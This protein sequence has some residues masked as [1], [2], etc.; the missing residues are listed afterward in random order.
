[1]AK[2]K[3]DSQGSVQGDSLLR[4]PPPRSARD[5]K[6]SGGGVGPELR[7]R[8]EK[9]AE[10]IETK[11]KE[12]LSPE[13]TRKTLHELQVH[14]IELE[15]Q[16]EELRRAQEAL[17][18][19]RVRY[20]DLF[21][22]A[23]V[24]YVVLSEQGLIL[25]ANL[26]SATMLAEERGALIKKPI[27]RFL[28]KEDQ[29][30]YYRHRKLLFE[31]GAPQVCEL[32]MARKDGALFWA[33]VE[34][35]ATQGAD[36]RPVCR[37]AISDISERKQIEEALAREQSLLD[38]LMDNIPDQVYFKD[39]ESRFIR[40]SKAQAKRFCLSDPAQAVGK[41]DFDIFTK[42]HAQPAFEN[43]R[44]I[45]RTGRPLVDLEEKEIWPDGQTAWVST[46]KVPLRDR[47]GQIIGTIGISRDITKRKRAEA[48]LQASES[49]YR[50][51]VENAQ[52]AI[53]VAQDDFLKFVNQKTIQM[54]G[55]AEPELLSRPFPEFIHP[56]DREMVVDR[57]QKR[58]AEKED[59]PRYAFRLLTRDA[60]AK[61]VEIGAV[62]IDWKGRPAILAFISDIDD[63]HKAEEAVRS[64]LREKEVMLREIHHRVKNNMQIVS[65]LLNLQAGTIADEAARRMLKEGQLR[66]RSMALVHEKLYRSKDF[67]KIDFADYLQSLSD[68]LFQFFNVEAGRIRLETDLE[69]IHLD[70]NSAVP[71]GLL[72]SELIS[73][74]LKHAFPAGR[75]GV[76]KLGLRR[77]TDGAVEIQVAD[78]GVGFPDSVDFRHSVSFGLQII[79]LL[80]EQL[81]GTIELNREKGTAFTIVFRELE[82]KPMA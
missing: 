29:D 62:L 74:A 13:E 53:L 57:Y 48:S 19:L 28:F 15:M 80:V 36:G 14:Q 73:N 43:E 38:A 40:I 64:S 22:L 8:A 37:A 71:C 34:A 10:A 11:V 69:N 32:R 30:I 82:Y 68:H 54:T 27:T 9:K 76:L 77:K 31:T 59:Q 46:T 17:E 12:T 18:A 72:F 21:D 44:K 33:R 51:L 45:M 75:K 3:F 78:D 47:Q 70:V 16:N 25:E 7:L 20:F 26:T 52:E 67:S 42:N 24:G 49:R 39:A 79:I 61:W 1:M 23:P 65:S 60:G 58:L 81:E 2:K 66:I 50:Q 5:G 63:R 56:D 55:Y 4:Q 6:G 35:T 41:T